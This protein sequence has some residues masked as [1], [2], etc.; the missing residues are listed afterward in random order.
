MADV[1][2]PFG[3]ECLEKFDMGHWEASG[4]NKRGEI[5]VKTKDG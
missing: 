4:Y 5:V 3:E 2:V 1:A